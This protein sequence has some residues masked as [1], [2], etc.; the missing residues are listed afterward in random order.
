MLVGIDDPQ[1]EASILEELSRKISTE[2]RNTVY[3]I[4]VAIV[5]TLV[6][7]VA[8]LLGL[9][10]PYLY[11]SG[12]LAMPIAFLSFMFLFRFKDLAVLKGILR[13][14][15]RCTACGY[16]LSHVLES[17]CPECGQART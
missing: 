2:H 14:R 7:L 9:Q 13:S 8:A 10:P 17:A 15:G 1:A 6:M 5:V 3:S 16:D 12:F 11:G 4:F